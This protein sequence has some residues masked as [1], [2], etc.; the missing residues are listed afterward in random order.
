[1]K[2][3]CNGKIYQGRGG[4]VK[5]VMSPMMPNIQRHVTLKG[6]GRDPQK[7]LRAIISKTAGDTDSVTIEHIQEMTHGESNGHMT[8]D[9]GEVLIVTSVC[10]GAR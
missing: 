4:G 8:D 7:C 6:Q 10:L 5:G 9:V 1:V 3:A 2:S